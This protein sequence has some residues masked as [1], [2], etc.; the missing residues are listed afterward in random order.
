MIGPLPDITPPGF[1]WYHDVDNAC[2][3]LIPVF[4]STA[5]M[6]S[7]VLLRYAACPELVLDE[8]ILRTDRLRNENKP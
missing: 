2:W 3:R 8:L 6:V 4:P 5:L 1:L 7:D